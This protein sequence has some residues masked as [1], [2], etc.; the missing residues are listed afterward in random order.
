MALKFLH[1]VQSYL[2]Y[3]ITKHRLNHLHPIMAHLRHNLK[4]K[5]KHLK[6]IHDQRSR[7]CC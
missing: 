7:L 2:T 3:N 1:L 4:H 6:T 5:S